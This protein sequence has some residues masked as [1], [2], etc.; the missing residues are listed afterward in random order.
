VLILAVLYA[1]CALGIS[2][3]GLNSLVLSLLY[4]R[5]R[6]DAPAPPAPPREW[7]SVVVQLPVYNERHVIA[8]LIDAAAALDYPPERL[9]IQV[10]DDSTDDTTAIARRCADRHRARGVD[11]RIVRRP[12][13]EGYKAGALAYGL[14][15]TDAAFVAVFDADFLPRPD[16]LR[17]TIPYFADP[18]VGI[19]QA[20]W[21]YVNAGYSPLT[22]AQA[23]ALD[24]HFTVEQT[25]RQRSGLLMNFSGTAGVIRRACIEGSGGWQG[26]TL[27]E[28]MD[29]SYRAQL[30]GWKG[31]HLVD[32]DAP[33][34]LP[35][36]IGSFKLQQARWATGTTQCLR[37]LG[38]RLLASDL[39]VWQ[40]VQ[41]LIHL[42]GYL[43]HPLMVLM[44][45]IGVPLVFAGRAVNLPL[46]PLSL[47]AFGPPLMVAISQR[48][49]YAGKSWWRR[50]VAFPLLILVGFGIAVSNT[51]GILQGFAGRRPVFRRTPKY[52]LVD[53]S[54]R[55]T[56][57][58]YNLPVEASTW[59]ELALA[60]YA[61]AGA[62]VAVMRGSGLAVI[63]AMY[64]L[65]FGYVGALGLWQ[66]LRVRLAWPGG[67]IRVES[68]PGQGEG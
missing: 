63:L 26:D 53:R 40:K 38:G 65:G 52:D 29:L 20:R 7:P 34:E 49:L 13:R 45:L 22:G 33:A 57:S 17:R 48:A 32:V 8:R 30:A 31:V 3:Y 16:F 46:V 6:R 37:K 60:L 12:D 5:H 39:T 36:T 58:A 43:L 10:L 56:T 66:A 41:A 62:A 11:V 4:L 18:A 67:Q 68:T 14:H 54:G 9:L 24:A 1:I 23:L 44:L 64:G 47:A 28:D 19:V 35:P 2:I 27:S 61:L 25:A 59:L 42:G 15:Q 55:W 21:S 51:Q 50:L